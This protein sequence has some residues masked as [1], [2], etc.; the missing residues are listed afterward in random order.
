[1]L[2]STPVSGRLGGYGEVSA[3]Q[4]PTLSGEIDGLPSDSAW[5]ERLAWLDA[6]ARVCQ[7]ESSRQR[8][9]VPV[10]VQPALTQARQRGGW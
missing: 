9:G 7:Q 1:M 5:L 4:R 10:A 6:S 8:F 3:R 2:D